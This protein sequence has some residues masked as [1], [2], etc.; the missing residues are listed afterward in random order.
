MPMLPGEKRRPILKASTCW[1]IAAS[2]VLAGTA[3]LITTSERHASGAPWR[4]VRFVLQVLLVFV[5]FVY[6]AYRLR[7]ERDHDD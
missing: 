6:A 2:G 3:W 7:R 1:G 4:A 5:M